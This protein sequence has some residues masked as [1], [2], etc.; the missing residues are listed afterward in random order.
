MVAMAPSL[1]D[2]SNCLIKVSAPPLKK[3]FICRL[4]SRVEADK[5]ND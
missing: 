4:F 1:D 3:D 2:I 5:F